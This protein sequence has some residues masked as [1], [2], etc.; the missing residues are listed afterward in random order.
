SATNINHIVSTRK[1]QDTDYVEGNIEV[2]MHYAQYQ[3]NE[4]YDDTMPDLENIPVE[5]PD[6]E[7]I[8]PVGVQPRV[9]QDIAH[10]NTQKNGT[11]KSISNFGS[12]KRK[13]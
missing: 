7:D 1:N 13:P 12:Q 10:T 9:N 3:P 6:L 4:T 2:D 5:M 8:L 11:H